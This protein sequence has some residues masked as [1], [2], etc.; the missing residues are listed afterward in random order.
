[1]FAS[2]TMPPGP[3]SQHT[4]GDGDDPAESVSLTPVLCVCQVDPPSI[5]R[6]T[7]PPG[8]IRQRLAGFDDTITVSGAPGEKA[9]VAENVATGGA[10]SAAA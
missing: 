8:T 7:A 1:M 2:S 6:W 10:D 3:T 9:F 4:E 5:V